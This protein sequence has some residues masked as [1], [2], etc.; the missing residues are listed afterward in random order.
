LPI[1]PLAQGQPAHEFSVYKIERKLANE[2]QCE[3]IFLD[4][5]KPDAEVAQTV[6]N[7]VEFRKEFLKSRTVKCKK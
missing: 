7:I 2:R 4:V 1:V 3:Q 5:I 6:V